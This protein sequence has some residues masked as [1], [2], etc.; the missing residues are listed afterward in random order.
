M[1]LIG[2]LFSPAIALSKGENGEKSK[3]LIELYELKTPND[4]GK[5]NAIRSA[6]LIN[7]LILKPGEIFSFNETI[8]EVTKNRGFTYGYFLGVDS[9]GNK[10]VYFDSGSGL[11]RTSTAIFQAVSD[12]NFEIIERHIIYFPESYTMA[13]N[14]ALVKRNSGLD[15]KFKN[16]KSYSIEIETST[17]D[18]GLISITIYQLPK[19]N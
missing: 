12:A 2:L 9:N 6:E 4:T 19:Q 15:F 13:C 5:T 11:W 8:G 3:I 7:G 10:K 16:N 1:L 18:S 14:S 17:D